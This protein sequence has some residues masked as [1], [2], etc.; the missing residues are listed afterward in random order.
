MSVFEGE[1]GFAA[2]KPHGPEPRP[3]RWKV[4][5][6][7]R[8]IDGPRMLTGTTG[9]VIAVDIPGF[10]PIRVRIDRRGFDQAILAPDELETADKATP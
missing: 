9:T 10:W 1:E 2:E 7:V 4:G 5:D 6:R 8:V 3:T